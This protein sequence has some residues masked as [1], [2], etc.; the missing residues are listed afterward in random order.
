MRLG[1]FSDQLYRREGSTLST[2]QAFTRFVTS[3]PPRVEEVVIFG[4]LDPEPGTSHYP[5]PT[6]DVRFVE[7]LHYAR[8]TDIRGQLRALRHARGAF[9]EALDTLDAVWI[10]GPHPMAVVFALSARRRQAPLVL[11]V[12]QDYPAY[13]RHRL[14]SRRWAWAVPVAH[15]LERIFRW[16]S[17]HSPTVALGD[18]LARRYGG[19]APVLSTNFSLVSRAELADRETAV[20][21]SWDGE[22]RILTVG[23]I[24][25]EK[26]PLLLADIAAELRSCEGRWHLVVVGEG[27]MQPALRRRLEEL[28]AADAVSLLGYIPNGP[29]LWREYAR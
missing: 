28:G 6:A 21:R 10:F 11:G 15:A 14:P 18:D 29:A 3:L 16:L 13:I 7:L 25:A 1:V 8:I 22:R 17:R 5:L 19:R 20:S 26:N 12:R 23:R 24:D 27:P 9:I 2:H 4:R